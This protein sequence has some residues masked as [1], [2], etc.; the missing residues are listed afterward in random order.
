[1]LKVVNGKI[2]EMTDRELELLE[3]SQMQLPAP[4][5]TAEERIEALEKIIAEQDAALME[6]AAMIA[7]GY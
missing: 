6:L 5:P 1:M 2:S 4:V 7:G 3:K